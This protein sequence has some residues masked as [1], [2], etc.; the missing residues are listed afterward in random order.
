MGDS[1]RLENSKGVLV[2]RVR[3]SAARAAPDVIIW[4]NR[5][6]VWGAPGDGA[7][8]EAEVL[9]ATPDMVVVSDDDEVTKP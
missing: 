7:Y 6:F 4:K 2:A 8:R 5:L 9:S 1:V 3:K